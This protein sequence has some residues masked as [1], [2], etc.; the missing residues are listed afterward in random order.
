M[1]FYRLY[2]KVRFSLVLSFSLLVTA[3]FAQTATV[4]NNGSDPRHETLSQQTTAVLFDNGSGGAITLTGS[5]PTT[6]WVLTVN[7]ITVT[8]SATLISANKV[9]VT[10]NAS[11]AHAGLEPYLLPGDVLLIKFT[12]SGTLKTGVSGNAA[13]GFSGV[14]SHNKWVAACGDVAFD[15]RGQRFSRRGKVGFAR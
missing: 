1:T 9:F 6:D 15:N 14:Q 10:F 8:T 4:V 7:A 11:A 12:N 5:T 2:S 13:L 3:A